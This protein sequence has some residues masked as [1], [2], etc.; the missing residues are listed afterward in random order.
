MKH[1]FVFLLALLM[2]V[3][4]AKAAE[5]ENPVAFGNDLF[6]AVSDGGAFD[7]D[8]FS[9]GTW[10][11]YSNKSET[12]TF[13][14][15][16]DAPRIFTF[17]LMAQD[18]K[19]HIRMLVEYEAGQYTQAKCDA[20]EAGEWHHYLGTYD[21]KEIKLYLDGKLV[22]TTKAPGR[23]TPSDDPLCIGGLCDGQRALDGK[24][25]DIRFWKR[26]LT[27]DE[28]KK[29]MAGEAVESGL[30]AQWSGEG[31]EAKGDTLWKSI[32]PVPITAKV[33]D[34][35][36]PQIVK[37]KPLDGFRGIWYYNQKQNNEYVYKY[38]GG[39]GTYCAK[40]IPFAVYAPKVNKTFFVY[41]GTDLKNSTL[42]HM[43]SY[44]D[45]ETGMVARPRLIMDKKTDDA[46]DNP[47]LNIDGDGYLWVFS[48][49]HGTGRP[50]YLWRSTKPYSIDEFEMTWKTNFSY[51][52]PHFLPG[53]GCLFL[54][55][56]YGG[57]KHKN[58]PSD[59]NLYAMS[60]SD[61]RHWNKPQRLAS[62]QLGGYQVSW[63]YKNK[64][65]AASNMHPTGKGLNWRTN[66]YY[67][68]TDDFGK[69]WKN[70]QG[71]KLDLPLTDADNPAL[72]T[73]YQSKGRN[74]YMKDLAFDSK[75]NPI[76]L[77]VTSGGWESGPK[78]DPRT[79][80]TVRWTGSEWETN[81]SITSDNNYDMGSLQIVNDNQ[82]RIVGPTETGPQPYN[83]GGEVAMWVTEDAGK[84]WKMEKQL[85]NDSPYNH[86]YCRKVV[87]GHP[88]FFSF[89]ADGHG[90]QPS[91]SRLYFTNQAGDHVWRLPVEMKED[92]AK[93]EIVE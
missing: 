15:R 12:Q 74:V 20:P 2:V 24:M 42:L 89:W 61:Y 37:T 69:T 41:G 46:H 6:A 87:N 72:I 59:R 30:V 38:S 62:I 55:T 26:A 68:E 57:G 19:P 48:S 29:A 28:V 16:S 93:P 8:H 7:C 70:V 84:T 81:G 73:D 49:S 35:A 63:A 65:G 75:G 1:A 5:P 52:Q 77:V 83:P 45:H 82:W 51:V 23:I 13:L 31:F 44:Y 39:L 22:S 91:E 64:V 18:Q 25:A 90:R 53:K 21:G 27:P 17:Y 14:S 36:L 60:S 54:H 78:N 66:L 85:T 10:V 9:V 11:N 56:R 80:T 92:F 40:H 76:I 43:I 50:S 4:F 88:D 47:V 3:P 34:A 71:E 33:T 79:W 86:T 67:M 58:G 32:G